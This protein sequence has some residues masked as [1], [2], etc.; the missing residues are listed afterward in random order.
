MSTN[1]TEL[2]DIGKTGPVKNRGDRV[3]CLTAQVVSIEHQVPLILSVMTLDLFG[4][5]IAKANIRLHF[6]DLLDNHTSGD[7]SESGF[8][9]F[10][11]HMLEIW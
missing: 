6:D 2:P 10:F 3:V 9:S 11:N 8:S 1:I 7:A 4:F 5:A